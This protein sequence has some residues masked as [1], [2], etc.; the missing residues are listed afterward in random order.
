MASNQLKDLSMADFSAGITN[1]Y[2]MSNR[3]HP[4]D[5]ARHADPER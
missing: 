2:V 5:R 3:A 1:V 4:L